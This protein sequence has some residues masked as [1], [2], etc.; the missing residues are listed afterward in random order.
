MKKSEALNILGLKDGFTE[1]EL[2]KAHRKKVVE[3]HP[4]RFQDPAEKAKAEER[5]KV[6]NE[7]NDILRSGKWDPEYGPRAHTS[8]YG[9][10]PYRNPYAG[11]GAEWVEIDPEMF[12][13]WAEQN[14]KQQEQQGY[15][16]FRP[17]V[18]TYSA[19]TPQQQ[20]ERAQRE[21][22]VWLMMLGVKVLLCGVQ[23][24]YGNYF[25]AALIWITIT[26]ML[27]ISSRFA[28]CGWIVMLALIPVFFSTASML[29]AAALQG[30]V[31]SIGL[32]G[33]LLVSALYFDF[34]DLMEVV[35]R[36][37]E[38]KKETE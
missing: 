6:I 21:V 38:A 31:I 16:P 11:Q 26:Y 13:R 22:R 17:F 36:Y 29:E 14:T 28:G 32:I 12:R 23:I 15:D 7:A 9:N 25:D 30:G 8:A 1:D 27:L 5:T 34:R 20:A 37:R 33:V 35:R 24:F 3:N 2:K 18:Y 10:G 19:P 4:D